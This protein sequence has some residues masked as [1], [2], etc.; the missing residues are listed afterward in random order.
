MPK[1]QRPLPALPTWAQPS[2]S[3]PRPCLSLSPKFRPSAPGP[4]PPGARLPATGSGPC[5]SP[6]T[7]FLA[8]GGPEHSQVEVVLR[9]GSLAAQALGLGHT[10]P[11][12]RHGATRPSLLVPGPQ[13]LCSDALG[14]HG[15]S[16]AQ[17]RTPS[18]GTKQRA[19]LPAKSLGP[20][21][22][23]VLPTPLSP[24]R[25]PTPPCPPPRGS[26]PAGRQPLPHGPT[27]RG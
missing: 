1:A 5:P 25:S 13:V 17:H 18:L 6:A 21:P 16:A 19:Q 10:E 23:P 26:V 20:L 15:R 4:P 24:P 7:T 3:G 14:A 2:P 22:A 27:L 9:A 11:V 8:L 12:L